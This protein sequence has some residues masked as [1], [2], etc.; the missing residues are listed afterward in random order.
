MSEPTAYDEIQDTVIEDLKEIVTTTYQTSDGME[1]SYPVVNQPL[2]DEQWQYITL[3]MGN[4]IFDT[5]GRPYNLTGFNNANNTAVLK[6]STITGTAQ[7]ILRGFYHRLINDMTINLPGVTTTTTYYIALCYDPIGH[8]SPTGP[9]S[10]RV[11]T[12]LDY[13]QGKHWLVL[14][15]VLRKPNQLLTD[16][17][18]WKSTPRVAPTHLLYDRDQL[19]D[20]SKCVWGAMYFISSTAEILMAVGGDQ[21]A[22]GP[23]KWQNLTSPPW[24]ETPDGSSYVYTGSGYRVAIKRQGNTR[25]LRG[26]WKRSTSQS[27]YPDSSYLLYM[28]EPGDRPKQTMRFKTAGPGTANGGTLITV[29]VAPNGEVQATPNKEAAWLSLDGVR[30]DT[31]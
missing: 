24:I 7:A 28:L 22:Q 21:E 10:V 12:V 30:F 18:V 20:P 2:N 3:A 29:T 5:G 17:E 27:F 6:V 9:I 31:E 4:G 8:D 11:V 19:P 16:A 26:Q 25:E 13:T 23:T 15:T 1:Y 14:W